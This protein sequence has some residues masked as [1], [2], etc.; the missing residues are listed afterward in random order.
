MPVSIDLRNPWFQF[1]VEA[2]QPARSDHESRPQPSAQS[3]L[4]FSTATASPSA[5]VAR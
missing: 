2:Q 3:L 4:R 5:A 1:N